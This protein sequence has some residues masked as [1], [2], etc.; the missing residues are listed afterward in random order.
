M[1]LLFFMPS[2]F[3]KI[4]IIPLVCG[5]K[6]VAKK[7]YILASRHSSQ[8]PKPLIAFNVLITV[9]FDISWFALSSYPEIFKHR[10]FHC[11]TRMLLVIMLAW[12]KNWMLLI[13]TFLR[14][15]PHARD[16]GA[17]SRPSDVLHHC[18]TL[19]FRF[20]SRHTVHSCWISRRQPLHS[21]FSNEWRGQ[22]EV[23]AQSS[24]LNN[25]VASNLRMNR[26]KAL[27]VNQ[28][29]AI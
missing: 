29:G 7:M 22:R 8:T 5:L 15:L 25:S 18:I 10:V 9:L 4:S 19:L 11:C 13:P 6:K 14:R 27:Q 17:H 24:R 21:P 26:I 12:Q 20:A 28:P 1:R 3:R 23:A 16:Y 2:G